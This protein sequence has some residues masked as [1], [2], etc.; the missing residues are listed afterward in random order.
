[1][2]ISGHPKYAG[3]L[4]TSI[5]DDAFSAIY[6]TLENAGVDVVMAG[7]THAFEYYVQYIKSPGKR[8]PAL[9]FCQRRR[10]SL[11][12]HRRC[13]GLAQRIADGGLGFLPGSGS[14]PRKTRRRNAS[15][16]ATDLDVDQAF[17]RLASLT[18]TLSGI[19][20]LNHAPFYQSF[21]EV[22]VERS[23]RRVV[24]A[25]HGANGVVYWRD[26]HASF[27][28]VTGTKPDAPVEF[29]VNMKALGD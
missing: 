6:A 18:E 20:D 3:G 19:F 11:P 13:S 25:L 15:L 17:R 8:A 4:D 22:R 12:Q 5:G 1:M 28:G 14:C 24:F 10:R 2:V 21:I 9:S 7:D 23:K 16:E 29:V 26:L 27:T